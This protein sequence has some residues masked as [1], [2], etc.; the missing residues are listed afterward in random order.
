MVEYVHKPLQRKPMIIKIFVT[1]LGLGSLVQAHSKIQLS[2]IKLA[3]ETRSGE[4]RKDS[5]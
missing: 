3:S 2:A 5:L 4:Y 1:A